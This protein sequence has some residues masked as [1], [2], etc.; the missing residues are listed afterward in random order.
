VIVEKSTGRIDTDL[1]CP[2][3]SR[4][5]VWQP[6]N[7]SPCADDWW[8]NRCQEWVEPD[9]CGPNPLMVLA[10]AVVDDPNPFA[11]AMMSRELKPAC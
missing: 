4:H 6:E 11:R 2:W 10:A 1:C 9:T 7:R 8:C 5:G 3:C